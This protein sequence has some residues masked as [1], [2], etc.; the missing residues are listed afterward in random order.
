MNYT[1]E[2]ILER[3]KSFLINTLHVKEYEVYHCGWEGDAQFW[4]LADGRKFT[5]NHGRLV[6]FNDKEFLE[7][8]NHLK[9][10]L[11]I[12]DQIS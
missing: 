12:I 8:K 9:S 4:V 6:L 5:T 3:G 2:E 10:Y 7:Y 1:T 11:A